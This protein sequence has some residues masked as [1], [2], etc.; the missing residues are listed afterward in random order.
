MISYHRSASRPARSPPLCNVR[1]ALLS[2]LQFLSH[3]YSPSSAPIVCSRSHTRPTTVLGNCKVSFT[4]RIRRPAKVQ[5]WKCVRP[6]RP[7]LQD[8]TNDNSGSRGR[9]PGQGV[10]GAK[11]LEAES[12]LI[13]GC[14]TEPANLA[15]FQKCLALQEMNAL[16]VDLSALRKTSANNWNTM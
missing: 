3:R 8:I 5:K 14:P 16:T 13:I 10:R 2:P 9:A 6:D 4:R 15:L 1:L 7:P 11:P 12:I